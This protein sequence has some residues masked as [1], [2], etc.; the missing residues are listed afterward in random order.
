MHEPVVSVN[1]N[2]L[3]SDVEI[4]TVALSRA[5][6]LVAKTQWDCWIER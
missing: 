3:Y 5:E 1:P 4:D 6:W 2:R